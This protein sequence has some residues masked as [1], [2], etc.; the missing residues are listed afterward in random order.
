M[1]YVCLILALLLRGQLQRQGQL[2]ADV[3]AKGW[4]ENYTH[5]G[6]MLVSDGQMCETR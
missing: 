5:E 1:F 2:E 6:Y 4:A 3:S